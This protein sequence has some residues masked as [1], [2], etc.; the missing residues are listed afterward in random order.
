MFVE[1]GME[2]VSHDRDQSNVDEYEQAMLSTK[3]E[4]RLLKSTHEAKRKKKCFILSY[5]TGCELTL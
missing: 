2:I 5:K 4:E 3:T 1:Y